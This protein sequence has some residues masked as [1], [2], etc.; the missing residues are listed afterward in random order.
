MLKTPWKSSESHEIYQHYL[1]T[2]EEKRFN[3]VGDVQLRY[4]VEKNISTADALLIL[5]GRTE[6]IEKYVELFY[7]LADLDIA[8]YSYD[9]RGQGF[10]DRTLTDPHKGHVNCFD[11][12][13]EDLRKFI[14]QVVAPNR[15]GRL[16]VLSHS[17]GG[18]ISTLF[19]IKYPGVIDGMICSAPMFGINTSPLSPLTVE[20]FSHTMVKLGMGDQYIFFKGGGNSWKIDFSGN[21]LTSSKSR[22]QSNLGWFA[23][24]PE[25]A[26]GS[27]T[28]NW[29]YESLAADRKILERSDAS[30]LGKIPIML[31]QGEKDIVV[32]ASAQHHFCKNVSS[33]SLQIIKGARHEL[34]MEEDSMRDQVVNLTTDFLRKHSSA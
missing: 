34:F 3:G 33:C 16:L 18:A 26:I 6:F 29:L 13:V 5:G 10:S 31:M 12:Y 23:E 24:N 32:T 14:D 30:R 2:F 22:F 11:D 27:P 25:L 7:N 20:K 17:M 21:R 19:Q 9:H 28:F 1:R 15:H 4:I 8:I